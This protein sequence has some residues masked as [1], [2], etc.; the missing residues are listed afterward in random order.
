M[1]RTH[2][3]LLAS[4]PARI[5]SQVHEVCEAARILVRIEAGRGGCCRLT[6]SVVFKT[7]F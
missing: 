6:P 7:A 4:R 2:G 5:E 3:P 1:P